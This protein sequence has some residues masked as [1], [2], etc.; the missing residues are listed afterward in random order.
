MRVELYGLSEFYKPLIYDLEEDEFQRYKENVDSLVE[1]L[2]ISCE[3]RV[4]KVVSNQEK[5]MEED[6]NMFNGN[7]YPAMAFSRS[8]YD[9]FD[10]NKGVLDQLSLD[11]NNDDELDQ[12]LNF[13]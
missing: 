7:D 8:E 2:R 9:E 1:D 4:V 5:I 6:A 10:E 11:G 12:F 3:D 13:D